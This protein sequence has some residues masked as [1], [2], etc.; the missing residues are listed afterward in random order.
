[1]PSAQA[2]KFSSAVLV[3]KVP[4]VHLMPHLLDERTTKSLN[5]LAWAVLEVV[6]RELESR[7][8]FTPSQPGNGSFRCKKIRD[9]RH[10]S[11]ML[12]HPR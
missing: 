6:Q 5:A 2:A 12:L 4:V 7:F 1:M 10:G 11:A 3:P 9:Q 8:P